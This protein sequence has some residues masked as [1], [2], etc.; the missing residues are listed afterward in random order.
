MTE[1]EKSKTRVTYKV[2]GAHPLDKNRKLLWLP[3]NSP[4]QSTDKQLTKA[5]K[6][7][8]FSR[9]INLE[10]LN[11]HE[12]LWDLIF[13]S[14]HWVPNMLHRLLMNPQHVRFYVH[15]SKTQMES[16]ITAN[17]A[18]YWFQSNQIRHMKKNS[19]NITESKRWTTDSSY[20]C[21]G[22]LTAEGVCACWK[23]RP[24]KTSPCEGAGRM[25]K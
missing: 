11:T 20:L 6:V 10:V 3:S 9:T 8:L 4:T 25:M 23:C 12:A 15:F 14:G 18:V 7:V 2:T 1:G 16:Q 5:I 13:S 22:F 17:S 21:A 19:Q 24:C